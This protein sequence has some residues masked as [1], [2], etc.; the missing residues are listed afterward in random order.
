MNDRLDGNL[1]L[2]GVKLAEVVVKW[3]SLGDGG[4]KLAEMVETW[5]RELDDGWEREVWMM[6]STMDY[7]ATWLNQVYLSYTN[8]LDRDFSLN[9]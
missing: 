8:V 7:G 5:E 2:I 9:F 4:E 3:R 6:G 1:I